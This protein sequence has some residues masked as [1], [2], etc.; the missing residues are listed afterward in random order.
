MHHCSNTN[1]RTHSWSFYGPFDN[2]KCVLLLN[3]NS[4][5]YPYAKYNDAYSLVCSFQYKRNTLCGDHA[6]IFTCCCW[7]LGPVSMPNS[8][9]QCGIY[10]HPPECAIGLMV[11]DQKMSHFIACHWGLSCVHVMHQNLNIKA[12]TNRSTAKLP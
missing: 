4:L 3:K 9:T 11:T 12:R 2:K 10:V 8:P 1:A 6:G 7:S 5:Q